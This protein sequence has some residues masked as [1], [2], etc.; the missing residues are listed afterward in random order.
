MI[1]R[2][3]YFFLYI[4]PALVALVLLIVVSRPGVGGARPAT[5][6]EDLLRETFEL[7]S[8]RYVDPVDQRKLAYG[9]VRGM[10]ELLDDYSRF[11]DPNER[12]ELDEETEGSFGGLGIRIRVQDGKIFVVYTTHDSPAA[13]AGIR[14]GDQ[15]VAVDG[16]P[17]ELGRDREA[18][19]RRLRGEPGSTVRVTLRAPRA[20]ADRTVL[21]TRDKVKLESVKD[22]RL[23]DGAGAVGYLRITG[24]QENTTE[25]FDEAVARLVK[26][27]MHAL[28]LD[29]R[30]NPGGVL[31]AAVDIADRFLAGGLIVSTRGRTPDSEKVYRA[32]AAVTVPERLPVV[33]LLNAESASASEVLA[34]ALQDHKR[35]LLVGTRTYGK[36]VVQSVLP[37]EDGEAMLR[38]TTAKYYTPAGRCI[39]RGRVEDEGAA[40]RRG[41]LLPDVFVSMPEEDEHRLLRAWEARDI[42]VHGGLPA[43]DENPRGAAVEDLLLHRALELLAGRPAL[44]R[45]RR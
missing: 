15:L 34:G 28:V 7:I 20:T 2:Q 35:A 21:V 19:S 1:G 33:V 11:Y 45:I 10:V 3:K 38:I 44:Q 30:F 39:D 42:V 8:R 40:G 17:L 18:I 23:L 24:F 5:P 14:P 25:D 22:V 16:A 26:L 9:A 36:G 12:R 37:V 4:S 29:L 27:G 41:G 6:A 43:P 32:D 13:K 31:K